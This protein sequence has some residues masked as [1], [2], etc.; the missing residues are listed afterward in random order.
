MIRLLLFLLLTT[1]VAPVAAIDPDAW[2]EADLEDPGIAGAVLAVVHEGRIIH[3]KG[4]G[5]AEIHGSYPLD[6]RVTLLPVGSVTKLFTWKAMEQL[7]A[8]GKLDLDGDVNLYLPEPIIP[9]TYP[10]PIT[11]T[12]LMTHTSGLDERITGLFV[13]DPGDILSPYETFV[14]NQPPRVRPAGAVTGYSNSGA[15]LA[16]AVIEEVSGMPYSQYIR[17]TILTPYGMS[18][19][20]FDPLPPFLAARYPGP[21][22]TGGVPIYSA[23]LPAGGMYATAEDMAIFMIHELESDTESRQIFTHDPR[24]PGIAEGGYMEQYR[25]DTRILMHSGDV[26]G[27]SSLLAIIPEEDL[28]IFIC[29]T[30]VGGSSRRYA[31]LSLF[32]G[33]APP[34][35]AITDPVPG[36]KEEY[37]GTYLSTRSP[38]TGF[39]AFIRVIAPAQKVITVTSRDDTLIIGDGIYIEAEP[40]Y[41]LGINNPGMLVFET[42]YGDDWLFMGETPVVAWRKAAWHEIPDLHLAILI[43]FSGLFLSAALIGGLRSLKGEEYRMIIILS[44]LAVLFPLL[45]FGSMEVSGLLFGTPPFFGVIL[46][47]PMA[48]AVLLLYSG[49]SLLKN[50][51]GRFLAGLLILYLGWLQYWNLLISFG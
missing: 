26:P 41:F 44:G 24:L 45:F 50:K 37:T 18:S 15:L 33:D 19:T 8:E 14:R 13:Q 29:Y 21:A 49:R 10:D 17:E 48:I 1:L 5:T 32:T 9:P 4:Y 25:G 36:S 42:R 22:L 7:A 51:E 39:E 20:G 46:W 28:G 16:G 31:L 34:G 40:G 38:E 2:I 11:P 12:H 35:A 47:M 30:G 3:L 23:Y 6:P 27:A 43:L